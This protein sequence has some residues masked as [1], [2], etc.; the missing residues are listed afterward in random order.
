MRAWSRLCPE[1][2]GPLFG[3]VTVQVAELAAGKASWTING[4]ECEAT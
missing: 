1:A 4:K 2:L 3:E